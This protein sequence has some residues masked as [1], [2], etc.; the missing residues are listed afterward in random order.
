M[1][2]QKSARSVQTLLIS[3]V[4]LALS[5]A[6]S[7]IANSQQPPMPVVVVSAEAV[8]VPVTFEFPGRIKALQQVDVFVRVSGILEQRFY[9]EGQAVTKGQKLYKID[10][11]RYRALV[12]QAKAQVVTAKAQIAQAEREYRRL[13]GLYKKQGV[14]QQEVDKAQSNLELARASLLAAQANLENAQIDLDYTSV[15]APISG[16]ISAKQQ[17]IGSLVGS[18]DNNRT[19]NSVTQ[20]D[21]VYVD[22]SIADSDVSFFRNN[23]NTKLI[24][25]VLNAQKKALVSGYVDFIDSKIDAANGK[26]AARAVFDNPQGTLMPGEFVRIRVV[27]GDYQQVYKI[28]QKAVLQMGAQAFVYI[29]DDGVAEMVPVGLAGAYENQWLVNK[30][31]KAGQQVIINNLIRLRPKSP[32]KV[33]NMPPA[34]ATQNSAAKSKP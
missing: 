6:G 20:M 11:R 5:Y 27:A 15:R 3:L 21:K 24:A 32:V 8:N 12:Q 31:L 13:S 19:L 29:V 30:G 14:S 25:E 7:A 9:T 2:M 17:D 4:A 34:N 16:I 10:E 23:D 1:S 18:N 28:P 33:M 22:F 26:V